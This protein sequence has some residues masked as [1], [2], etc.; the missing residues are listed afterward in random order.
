MLLAE[1]PG[2]LLDSLIDFFD[3]RE[4]RVAGATPTAPS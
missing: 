3:G 2:A 1:A 4:G